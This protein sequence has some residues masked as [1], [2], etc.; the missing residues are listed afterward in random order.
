[1]TCREKLK[2]EHPER[3]CN[4]Y[5]AGCVGCPHTY[6]YL[7][8]PLYCIGGSK[9]TC[10]KCWDREIP[11]P[12]KKPFPI[13]IHKLID[14]AMEKKDRSVSLFIHG[15]SVTVNVNPLG[16]EP[17]W[18]RT[19]DARYQFKCSECGV[20]TRNLSNYCPYCGEKLKMPE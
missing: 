16:D 5:T 11:E 17:K 4:A 13:D 14:E 9:S 1:M 8:K 6:G 15:D 10:T 2:K 7:D 19:T 12:E 3:F 20:V 18:E